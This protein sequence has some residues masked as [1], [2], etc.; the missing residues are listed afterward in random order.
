MLNP[1]SVQAIRAPGRS[2]PRV[3]Q[4]AVPGLAKRPR[5]DKSRQ[6]IQ[7]A[8]PSCTPVGERPPGMSGRPPGVTSPVMEFGTA[9][10]APGSSRHGAG[11]VFRPSWSVSAQA[12]RGRRPWSRSHVG[13]SALVEPWPWLWPAF[14]FRPQGVH[15]L[16]DD[17]GRPSPRAP[18]R[19][20]VLSAVELVLLG[21]RRGQCS[22]LVYLR[23]P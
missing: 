6:P 20:L 23:L 21:Q 2:E 16:A 17:R 8:G 11:L 13:S 14:N 1:T 18:D 15:V 22:T 19:N 3:A 7:Q 12:E 4:G 9:R 5:H 10:R